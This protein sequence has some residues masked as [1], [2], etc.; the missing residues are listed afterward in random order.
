M[1]ASRDAR[2][3]FFTGATG[4]LAPFVIHRLL[5]GDR[6]PA[7]FVCLVRSGDG[8]RRLR[9]RIA[10]ICEACAPRVGSDDF[11]F[12]HGDVAEPIGCASPVDAVWH[13]AADLRFEP[14]VA[15]EVRENNL[16]GAR[17]I[18]EFCDKR[19]AAL[20]FVSTAYVCGKRSGIIREDEL[21]C[22]QAF[23]NE[24]E[25]S[26][27]EAESLA[28]DWLR[29]H[30]GTIL[31]P[32]IVLGDF[33]T[34]TTLSFHGVFQLLRWLHD[35]RE[36]LLPRIGFSAESLRALVIRLPVSFPAPLAE[37]FVNLVDARYAASLMTE[38]AERPQANG[39]T[40]HIVNPTPPSGAELLELLRR[41]LGVRAIEPGNGR[42]S[43]GANELESRVSHWLGDKLMIYW[44]Y[45]FGEHPRFDM[46]NV[47]ETLGSP[48]AHPSLDEA[49]WDRLFKYSVHREFVP[50]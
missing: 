14:E 36:H 17:R 9:D 39:K 33:S 29:S 28:R 26:K 43:P 1:K 8:R 19:R 11:E 10:A 13:F 4:S 47:S 24:Y 42:L 34:G 20:Y 5:H 2:R 44:P 16:A 25:S 35:F 22:G 49:A 3:Y 48:P 18:L 7:S 23:R 31:R 30:T 46:S 15:A 12:V 37:T 38:L 27:A 45:L 32:S 21:L 40:F 50:V 6:H 41:S